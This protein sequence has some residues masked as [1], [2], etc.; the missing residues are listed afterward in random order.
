MTTEVAVKPTANG[1]VTEPMSAWQ[2]LRAP[3]EPSQ[4][5]KRKGAGGA[6]LD[7]VSHARVRDRL[8]KVDPT[9]TWEPVAAEASGLPIFV[10]FTGDYEAPVYENGRK[11]MESRHAEDVPVGLW[12]KLTVNGVGKLGYGDVLPGAFNPEKQ[13]IGDAIR[14]AAM[15]FGVA[16]DLWMKDEE[17]DERTVQTAPSRPSADWQP[18]S[19]PPPAAPSRYTDIPCTQP[20]CTGKLVQR[21]GTHGPFISCT[22]YASCGLKPIDG[23]IEEWVAREEE[24]ADAHDAP[25]PPEMPDPALGDVEYIASVWKKVT[26][27]IRLEAFGVG[28]LESALSFNSKKVWVL[29]DA[30]VETLRTMPE[31]RVHAVAEFF[32]LYLAQQAAQA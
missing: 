30:G 20:G 29:A 17:P 11:R 19:P 12:I 1:K 13:L 21:N 28:K 18:V 9:W 7:Y 32:K 8:L 2:E 26:S 4:I 15:N 6:M 16:I 31:D 14:N 27:N 25:P 24:L 3:F 10:R 23:T 5:E 22:M